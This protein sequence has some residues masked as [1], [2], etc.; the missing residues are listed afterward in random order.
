VE[1]LGGQAVAGLH[2]GGGEN[3]HETMVLQGAGSRE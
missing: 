2:L 3:V 1:A